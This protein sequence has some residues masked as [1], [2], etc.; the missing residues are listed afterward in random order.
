MAL[1]GGR[2]VEAL[3]ERPVR[4]QLG[5]PQIPQGLTR[6]RKRASALRQRRQTAWAMARPRFLMFV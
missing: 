3:G 5:P 2:K 4:V 6:N 1:L